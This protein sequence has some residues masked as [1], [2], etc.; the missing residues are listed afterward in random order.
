[1][2]TS[3]KYLL[4]ATIGTAS[5]LAMLAASTGTDSHPSPTTAGTDHDPVAFARDFYAQVLSGDPAACEV[6]TAE[7]RA[8]FVAAMAPATS[9]RE[10]VDVLGNAVG[11]EHLAEFTASH[12]YT[13]VS[14]SDDEAV[15]RANFGTSTDLMDLHWIDGRWRVG[16][17]SSA[18]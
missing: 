3:R 11:A 14:R 18:P 4:A 10:A 5:V 13:L 7:G 16:E 15:V 1:M 9:C 12:T 17:T 2:R 6:F 8:D